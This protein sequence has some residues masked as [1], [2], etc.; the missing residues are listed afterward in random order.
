M[1]SWGLG[2][3][4]CVLGSWIL[5]LCE[6]LVLG[7]VAGQDEGTNEACVDKQLPELSNQDPWPNTKHPN[8]SA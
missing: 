5:G 7:V 3:V 2:V 1:G 8:T 4:S 6:S